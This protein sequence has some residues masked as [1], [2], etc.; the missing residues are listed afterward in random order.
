MLQPGAAARNT[1]C[2]PAARH[3]GTRRR[4]TGVY[5]KTDGRRRPM[6]SEKGDTRL[7]IRWS[8]MMH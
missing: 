6:G 5:E 8:N 1:Q 3:H 4:V 2:V 7:G